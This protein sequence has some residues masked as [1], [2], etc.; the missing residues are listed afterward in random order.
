MNRTSE[1]PVAED[2]SF[3]ELERDTALSESHQPVTSEI[4]PLESEDTDEIPVKEDDSFLELE[5]RAKTKVA[6]TS[7]VENV[8]PDSTTLSDNVS[9]KSEASFSDKE[10][11]SDSQA[12]DQ[13]S[14][15]PLQKRCLVEK[16]RYK[17]SQRIHLRLMLFSRLLC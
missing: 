4:H 8:V 11:L 2:D 14:E 15:T 16:L 9:A 3:L 13:F 12:S 6:D 17:Q 10:Q 1:V 7:E 5:D